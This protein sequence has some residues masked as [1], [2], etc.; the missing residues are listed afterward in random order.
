MR[1]NLTHAKE[2]RKRAELDAQLLANRI[3]LLKQ[4]E[5]KAWKK[6]EETRTRA[7]EITGLRELNEG[8]FTAKADYY[9][10]RYEGV[11]QAQ[12]QN[13]YNRDRRKAHKDNTTSEIAE[14]K[15]RNVEETRK[16]SEMNLRVKREKELLE[17][18]MNAQRSEAIRRQKEEA[19]A[20]IEKEKA[21]KLAKYKEDYENRV[22]QEE[23]LRS[24]TEALVAQM[25]KEEMEL[26]QRLQNTQNVQRK[27]YEDLEDALNTS[28]HVTT[29][30]MSKNA[31]NRQKLN[32]TLP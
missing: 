14:E 5:E 26:I 28:A 29:S 7:D 30:P 18:Q 10:T 13:A 15:R 12:A 6:I 20:R 27:A 22:A 25:E 21:E 4:E 1:N 17:Q 31:N 3:A 2:S 23:M 16:Q 8:K 24:R 32:K 9:N 19:K 11:K